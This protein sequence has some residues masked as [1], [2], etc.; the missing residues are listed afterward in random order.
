MA[1]PHVT[2]TLGPI[3]FEDLEPRRFED[4]ARELIYDFRDWQNIEA[5]GRGGSDDGFDVRAYERAASVSTEVSDDESSEVV[6]HPMDGNVWMIQC[7]RE[8]ELGPTRVRDIIADGVNPDSPPY[9][10]ILV[11]PANFSKK[12]YDKFREELRSRG[13]MEFHLWGRAELEDMLY[14]PKNDHILFAFFGISLVTRRRSRSTEIRATVTVKNKLQKIMGEHPQYEAVLLRDTNDLQYPFADEYKDF[15]TRPRWKEYPVVELH[16]LG[17]IVEVAEYFA[18]L[19]VDRKEW[20]YTKSVNLVRRHSDRENRQEKRGLRD[21]VEAFWE[22]FRK[23]HQAKFVVQ[24]LLRF[25][26]IAVVDADGDCAHKFPHIYSE[27]KGNKGPFAWFY[28]EVR[29][30]ERHVEYPTGLKQIKKFPETFPEPMVATIHRDTAIRLND[31]LLNYFKHG[32]RLDTLYACDDRFD[33]LAVND[34]IGIE[35][36]ESRDTER[37]LIKVTHKRQE[38]GTEYLAQHKD[39]PMA[40]RNLEDHI[41]RQIE[42]SDTITVIEFKRVYDWQ[43]EQK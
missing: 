17:L 15:D 42:P 25:D 34:V 16:P 23:S 43:L 24:G 18:Y 37:T 2:R 26:S 21:R 30:N 39:D 36:T 3:H 31:R 4:L 22:S 8:K 19:D 38:S 29:I 35:G 20:D 27:F 40:A 33:F 7:K 41:G 13:V 28:E 5:T 9:G 10:Y 1:R 6:T 32:S 12:A 11:A 14:Q